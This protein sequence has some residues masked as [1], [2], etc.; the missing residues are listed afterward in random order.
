MSSQNIKLFT[1][2]N[3][4][5][6]VLFTLAS[7]YV[8]IGFFIN[9]P[10]MLQLHWGYQAVILGIKIFFPVLIAL[11]IFFYYSIRAKKIKPGA[12]VLLCIAL[13][14]IVSL[15]YPV[16]DYFYQEALSK[17]TNEFHTYLQLNPPDVPQINYSSYNIFCLGGSTTEFKDKAG[18]DWTKLV[19]EKLAE[20]SH[21]KPIKLYN[22]GKQWYTTQHS[23][24]NYIQNLREHKPDL[25]IVMHNINDLLH[26]ADFSRFSGGAF[27]ADYG[28]FLGPFT[29][30]V[31]RTSLI[32][33]I[34]QTIGHNWYYEQPEEVNAVEFA[35]LKS[36]ENNL[37]TLIEIC[38]FD[39]T[40][41]I[42]MTEP[43]MYKESMIEEELAALHMLN[44]EAVG[45]GKRW[46]FRTAMDGLNAYNQKTK[47]IALDKKT[48]FIDLDKAVP[49]TLDYFYDDVHYKDQTYDLISDYISGELKKLKPWK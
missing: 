33:M 40:K 5:F 18:R 42:L 28:H 25:I 45:N 16:G 4:I 49:K 11:I 36:F 19:E 38:S 14:V 48:M 7:A 44:T 2:W 27:R 29:N 41:I 23:L 43:N 24:T 9:D 21:S 34:I 31:N 32:Q 12:V 6:F 15:L 20:E 3:I 47:Q 35:G 37:K 39:K 1:R 17:K 46:S 13:L 22:F 26:N 10:V 8:Y 30:L